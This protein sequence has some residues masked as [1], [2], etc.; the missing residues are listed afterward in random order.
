M[1]LLLHGLE[2]ITVFMNFDAYI[3]PDSASSSPFRLTSLSHS[4]SIFLLLAS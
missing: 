4:L 2:C 1:S 3:V